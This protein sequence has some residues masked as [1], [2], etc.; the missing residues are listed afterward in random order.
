MITTVW[1]TKNLKKIIK[2]GIRKIIREELD[3][4]GWASD[5]P[6]KELQMAKE[7]LN[8]VSWYGDDDDLIC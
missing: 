7:A 3:A 5:D 2:M 1:V 4:W 8:D 6:N